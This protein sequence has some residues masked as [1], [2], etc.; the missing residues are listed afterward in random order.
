MSAQCLH[1]FKVLI[2]KLVLDEKESRTKT[3]KIY[4]KD[5]LFLVAV[6][7]VVV[8]LGDVHKTNI[9]EVNTVYIHTYIHM[10]IP[11]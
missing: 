6:V 7:V 3:K 4:K 10:H 2:V 8:V 5:V 1:T 9:K 11:F